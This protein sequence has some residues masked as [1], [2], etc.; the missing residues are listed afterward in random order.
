MN[1]VRQL[2]RRADDLDINTIIGINASNMKKFKMRQVKDLKENMKEKK[3][4][5]EGIRRERKVSEM[6]ILI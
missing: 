1:K 3:R 5:R 2:K 6:L 4:P